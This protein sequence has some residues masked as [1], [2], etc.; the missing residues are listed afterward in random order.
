MKQYAAG[1]SFRA[2][3]IRCATCG[4]A[5]Q[6]KCTVSSSTGC[7]SSICFIKG[8]WANDEPLIELALP[9]LHA[10]NHMLRC[11]HIAR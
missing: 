4:P 6:T 9:I 2:C 10:A 8:G 5:F 3:T 11:R 1:I 7:K